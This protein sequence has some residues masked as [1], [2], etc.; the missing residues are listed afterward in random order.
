MIQTIAICA[1]GNNE[2]GFGHLMRTKAL[3]QELANWGLKL[4][5]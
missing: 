1:D 2:I 3:A 4:F 5:C